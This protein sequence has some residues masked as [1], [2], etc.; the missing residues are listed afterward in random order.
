MNIT[1][2]KKLKFL[3]YAK[4]ILRQGIPGVFYRAALKNKLAKP[5]NSD[6]ADRVN[7][8]NKLKDVI[9]LGDKAI[10]LKNMQIFKS[11][12]AYN[13]DAFEYT[14]Y[15]NGDLK[16]NFLVGDITYVPEVPTIQKSRP[17]AGENAKAV[18][19]NLDKYRHFVFVQD[20]KPFAAKKDL[21]IGR[22]I[23]TQ[24]HRIKF[25]EMHFNNPMCDV[26][27]VNAKEGN[28]EWLKPKVSIT[29][30]LDYKFIL[31]LEGN[32]VATN[33]KWIM[34]SN[35]VAVMPP[36]KYETWFM[37]GRLIPGVHYIGISDDYSDLDEKLKYY[38]QH[39]AEAEQ[40]ARN[41]NKY[42]A[43]FFDKEKE[44]TIALLVLQKY[45]KYTGQ[46]K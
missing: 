24:P 19:L 34:S 45:F 9:G 38:M 33:L 32:D 30:H 7:Y 18:L 15:F 12:K 10:A 46:I 21:L 3:Y 8:Y 25:M 29:D 39:T 17:I 27:Q 2:F 5:V 43:Q 36:P 44:D 41:A 20:K 26:G 42:V 28:L 6:I 16:M 37:E 14:R 22:G 13:F 31:S 11:P 40:I 1:R 35:S 23:V 4:N